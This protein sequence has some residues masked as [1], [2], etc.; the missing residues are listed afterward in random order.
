MNAQERYY[1]R[2]DEMEREHRE[3]MVAVKNEKCRKQ[4]RAKRRKRS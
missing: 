4:A 1:R 2:L 3:F